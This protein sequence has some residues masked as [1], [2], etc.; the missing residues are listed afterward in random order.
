MRNGNAQPRP[1]VE[2]VGEFDLGAELQRI[3]QVQVVGLAAPIGR[4]EAGGDDEAAAEIDVQQNAGAD[5]R[6]AV[7][8]PG[9]GQERLEMPDLEVGTVI[10]P[11][12]D[13]FVLLPVEVKGAGADG[14]ES[15]VVSMGRRGRQADCRKHEQQSKKGPFQHGSAAPFNDFPKKT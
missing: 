2:A 15:G 13:A 4:R 12:F 5:K 6:H 3:A 1:V 9:H 10:D 11:K 8:H 7:G 14:Q